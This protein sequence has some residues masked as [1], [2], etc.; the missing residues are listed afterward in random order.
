MGVIQFQSD[1]TQKGT[2][3]MPTTTPKFVNHTAP[4]PDDAAYAIDAAKPSSDF[5]YEHKFVQVHD[6]QIAYVDEGEGD[7]IVFVHGAPESS[8]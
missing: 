4:E 1:S 5:P 6:A 7:P 8:Y 3:L 2:L